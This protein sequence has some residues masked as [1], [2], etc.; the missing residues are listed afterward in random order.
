M[1]MALSALMPE[2]TFEMIAIVRRRIRHRQPTLS[3]ARWQCA[4][5]AHGGCSPADE[6]TAV[7]PPIPGWAKL[8]AD[9]GFDARISAD[10]IDATR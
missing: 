3:S 5:D 8:R 6:T 10:D 2:S 9:A 7:L 1:P 4:F